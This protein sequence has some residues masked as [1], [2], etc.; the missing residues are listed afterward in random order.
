MSIPQPELL[1]WP[2]TAA[3]FLYGMDEKLTAELNE[4]I[5]QTPDIPALRRARGG[6]DG[7]PGPN[8]E[9]CL[10]CG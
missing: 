6:Q 3:P 9:Q 4:I 8:A 10:S 2:E 1:A 7:R 5:R